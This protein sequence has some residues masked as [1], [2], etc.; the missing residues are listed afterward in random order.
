MLKK[1]LL[2]LPLSLVLNACSISYKFNG[3]S[4]DYN[5][6]KTISIKDFPNQAT[7]VNPTLSA[8]FSDAL[9]NKYIR[10]TKLKM[11]E[12]NA[13]LEL[14]G[15]ITGYNVRGMAVKEDAYAS[16]TELSITVKVRYINNKK[17]GDDID[18]SF[19]SSRPFSNSSTLEQVQDQL[20]PEIVDDLVDQI[21]TTTLGNW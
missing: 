21:Y 11:V 13:D 16:M 5:L 15:E 6:V 14:E 9:R 19:T 4:V 3:A 18:Q 20:V 10:Q 12:N 2:L 1:I 8:I 7:L 17:Q